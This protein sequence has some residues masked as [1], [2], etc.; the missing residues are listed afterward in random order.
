[1][2][3]LLLL[4]YFFTAPAI[5]CVHAQETQIELTKVDITKIAGLVST[6]ISIF[7]VM[8]G[9]KAEEAQKKLTAEPS[10]AFWLSGNSIRLGSRDEFE[11]EGMMRTKGIATFNITDGKIDSMSVN[12]GFANWLVGD[13]RQLV[14][15][16]HDS[17]TR[18]KL[19]GVEDLAERTAGVLKFIY[20]KEGIQVWSFG[21]GIIEFVYP[22]KQR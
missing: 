3:I 11:R 17:S 5:T 14:Q 13:T 16:A 9:D 7:G 4:I 15:L 12:E 2:A 18:R 22:P 10:V 6:K 19:L 20:L 21:V 8:L 1:L